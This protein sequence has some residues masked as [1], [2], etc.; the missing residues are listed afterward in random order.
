MSTWKIG[1]PQWSNA[2]GHEVFDEDRRDY[3]Q[4]ARV[5]SGVSHETAEAAVA[6]LNNG[7]L[8]D[9]R[10]FDEISDALEEALG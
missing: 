8:A 3:D 1:L 7:A 2:E 4:S 10:D 5:L 9:L 6:L